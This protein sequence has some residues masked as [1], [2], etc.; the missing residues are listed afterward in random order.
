M[1]S[2]GPYA[3]GREHSTA[4]RCRT[5]A[6]M[7]LVPTSSKK[8]V[9]PDR[10][11]PQRPLVPRWRASCQWPTEDMCLE[12]ARQPCCPSSGPARSPF[13]ARD[14][15]C[16]DLFVLPCP[17]RSCSARAVRTLS[18]AQR[19]FSQGCVVFP[20]AAPSATLY[21]T[22]HR[23]E[24]GRSSGVEHNLAKVRVVSSNLIARSK[25]SD[26]G[27]LSGPFVIYGHSIRGRCGPLPVPCGGICSAQRP[28]PGSAWPDPC[29]SGQPR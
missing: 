5:C 8:I 26:E 1:A 4:F 18:R 3:L 24:C 16:H 14:C 23:T 22:A 20:L 10:C 17:Q 2:H 28:G 12:A 29:R 13:A 9:R 7:G 6:A 15:G 27:P 25:R 19:E 11:F 21:I